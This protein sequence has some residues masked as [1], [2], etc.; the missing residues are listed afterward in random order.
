ML[1]ICTDTSDVQAVQAKQIDNA[2]QVQCNF[3][4]YSDAQ[5]CMVVLVG[6]TVNTTVNVTRCG[7]CSSAELNLSSHSLSCY[8]EVFAFDIESDGSVGDLAIVGEL[9]T[10]PT[11]KKETISC[12]QS[13]Q[14][15]EFCA[16]INYCINVFILSIII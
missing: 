4:S 8:R 7:T 1:F 10:I 13:F 16:V 11:P 6:D 3:I 15:G 14:S 12:A 2:I 5:G 9:I